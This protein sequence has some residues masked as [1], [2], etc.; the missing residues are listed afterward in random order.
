ML[1]K[2]GWLPSACRPSARAAMPCVMRGCSIASMSALLTRAMR[3]L[4]GSSAGNVRRTGRSSTPSASSG[5]WRSRLWAAYGMLTTMSLW[6]LSCAIS[7]ATPFSSHWKRVAPC[8]LA[9]SRNVASLVPSRRA[10]TVSAAK[11]RGPV[12]VLSPSDTGRGRA[13][14]TCFQCAMLAWPSAPLKR[15]CSPT[16]NAKGEPGSEA[17]AGV[18]PE[19]RAR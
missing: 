4:N 6:P 15:F 13:C 12:G 7:S 11:V 17:Q 18:N 14:S 19:A 5:A 16:A 3:A 2:G 10:R 1:L 9:C 8:A